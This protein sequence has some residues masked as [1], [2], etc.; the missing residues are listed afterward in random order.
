MVFR[1]DPEGARLV[2]SFIH[3]Q[4]LERS[5]FAMSPDEAYAKWKAT[6]GSAEIAE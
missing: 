2:S 1:D 4:W 3:H 5:G 6:K